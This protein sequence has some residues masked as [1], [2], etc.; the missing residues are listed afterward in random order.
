[1]R[2]R[3]DPVI[4][5]NKV[6]GRGRGGGGGDA[7]RIKT[8]VVLQHTA[9]HCCNTLQ[10][11]KSF[12]RCV[13]FCIYTHYRHHTRTHAVCCS[14][15]Q[16]VAVCCSVL[17]CVAVCCSALQCVAVCCSV[18]FEDVHYY[19]STH[20]MCTW[21]NMYINIHLYTNIH[22]YMDRYIYMYICILTNIHINIYI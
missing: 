13:L 19:V 12:W 2:G 9:T 11:T 14:V 15:L 17:Q 3:P 16:C 1:M 6:Q 7:A 5:W 4:R 21:M 8:Y 22:M 20:I 18:A 10:H